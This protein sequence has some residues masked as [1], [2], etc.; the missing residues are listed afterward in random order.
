MEEGM[1]KPELIKNI[2]FSEAHVLVD[3]VDYE[4]GRVKK[5]KKG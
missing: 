1:D 5:P 3:L 2:P 4:K